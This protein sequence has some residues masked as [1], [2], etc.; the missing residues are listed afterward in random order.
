MPDANNI[1]I[2]NIL[3]FII[4]FVFKGLYIL[5]TFSTLYFFSKALP[6]G[7]CSASLASTTHL[8]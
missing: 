1:P 2:N 5:V 7:T 3:V 6:A 4:L 8:P